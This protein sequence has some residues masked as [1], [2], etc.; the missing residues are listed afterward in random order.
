MREK[1]SVS[2]LAQRGMDFCASSIGVD[3]SQVVCLLLIFLFQKVNVV[4]G[5]HHRK[6]P[7]P[8]R[9]VQNL[10]AK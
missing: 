9:L 1:K 8:D 7:F 3:G 10:T 4:Q 5:L 2:F 6:G